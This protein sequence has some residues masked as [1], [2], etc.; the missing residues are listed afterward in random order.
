MYQIREVF[1]AKPGKAKDLVKIFKQASPHFE[2]TEGVKNTRVLTDVVSDYW[3]VV[4]ESE[5]EDI[6]SFMS[7][8]RSATASPELKE[9]MKGYMDFVESGYRALFLIE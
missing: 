6:G 5:V 3:T 2:K 8:L 1:K 4:I 9:I 7:K